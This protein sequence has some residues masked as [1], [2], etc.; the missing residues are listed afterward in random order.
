MKNYLPILQDQPGTLDDRVCN[1]LRIHRFDPNGTEH[2]REVGYPDDEFYTYPPNKAIKTGLVIGTYASVPYIHLSLENWQRN[3]PHI[4]VLVHDDCSP[5]QAQLKELCK[6]YGAAFSSNTVNRGHTVGDTTSFIAGWSWAKD[7]DIDILVKFSRRF[8]PLYNWLPDL[9]ALARLTQYPTFSNVC[10]NLKWGF[11]S[12]CVGMHI[13]TWERAN[14]L[15]TIKKE[16][17]WKQEMFCEHFWHE[18]ARRVH[19]FTSPAN[20]SYT[21]KHP[22]DD[23]CSGYAPW[24]LLGTDRTKKVEGLIWHHSCTP[25]E[26]YAVSFAWGLRYNRNDFGLPEGAHD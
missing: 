7:H 13:P 24:P 9:E 15:D 17:I 6:K 14:V 10:H 12:E 16:V 19:S 22:K 23:W 1:E 4:P 26:Y 11:R 8:L 2:I 3:F 21:L 25:D 18:M 20:I 5:K